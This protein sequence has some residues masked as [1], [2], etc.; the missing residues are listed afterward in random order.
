M[1]NERTKPSH[2]C[3]FILGGKEV[4]KDREPPED[5]MPS[6]DQL[7]MRST[8]L[9]FYVAAALVA[10]PV[11]LAQGFVYTC[12][13]SAVRVVGTVLSTTCTNEKGKKHSTSINLNDCVAN[14]DGNLACAVK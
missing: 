4:I 14:Y 5:S 12:D 13:G 10:A 2:S 11:T 3:I 1:G 8:H 7:A 9:K 6:L